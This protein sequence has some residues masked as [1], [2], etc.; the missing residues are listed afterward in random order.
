MGWKTRGI[1]AAGEM[2]NT[3]GATLS[4]AREKSGDKA[5]QSRE[6]TPPEG[7][8]PSFSSKRLNRGIFPIVK[9][10][11]SS[12]VTNDSISTGD[13]GVRWLQSEVVE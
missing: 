12:A 10:V 13:H 8:I 1:E 3:E 7:S 11:Y 5:K 2:W 4:G 9:F 6:L